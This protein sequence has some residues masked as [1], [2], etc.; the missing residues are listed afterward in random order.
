MNHFP[1]F[2]ETVFTIEGIYPKR[3]NDCY[4]LNEL[5]L[6]VGWNQHIDLDQWSPINFRQFIDDL[7]QRKDSSFKY[8]MEDCPM[9]WTMNNRKLHLVI[10]DDPHYPYDDKTIDVTEEIIKRLENVYDAVNSFLTNEINKQ[11]PS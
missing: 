7:K 4:P 11:T 1:D 5:C 10:M 3:N 8:M 6:K 9:E 2:E